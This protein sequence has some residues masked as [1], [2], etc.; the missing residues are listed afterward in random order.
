VE[1]KAS[2]YKNF[3][4]LGPAWRREAWEEKITVFKC[5]GAEGKDRVTEDGAGPVGKT[6]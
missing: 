5:P 6:E 3:Q 4:N 1:S 2:S